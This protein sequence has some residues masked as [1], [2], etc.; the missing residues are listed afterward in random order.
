MSLI[1]KENLSNVYLLLYSMFDEFGL[2]RGATFFRFVGIFPRLPP[3]NPSVECGETRNLRRWIRSDSSVRT[4]LINTDP[5]HWLRHRYS[6]DFV[7]SPPEAL[8]LARR[9]AVSSPSTPSPLN[10]RKETAGGIPVD[11]DHHPRRRSRLTSPS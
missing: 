11:E 9:R 5:L 1:P 2:G 10:C 4:S 3:Q 8:S 6:F 7:S